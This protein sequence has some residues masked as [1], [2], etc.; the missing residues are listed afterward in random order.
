MTSE[1]TRWVIDSEN[2]KRFSAY[3]VLNDLTKRSGSWYSAV[4]YGSYPPE[5]IV[6]IVTFENHLA[7]NTWISA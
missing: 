1:S 3:T 6:A 4:W 7:Q 5:A 2:H